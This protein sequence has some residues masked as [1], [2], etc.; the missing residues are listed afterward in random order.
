[1]WLIKN[2]ASEMIVEIE[3]FTNYSSSSSEFEFWLEFLLLWNVSS[4]LSIMLCSLLPDPAS[5]IN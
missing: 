5:S 2:I 1:M 3:L 4:E